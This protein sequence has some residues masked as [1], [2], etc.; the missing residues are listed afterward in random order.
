MRRWIS[1]FAPLTLLLSATIAEAGDLVVVTSTAPTFAPGKMVA[2]GAS[3]DLPKGAQ[4]TLVSESGQ[5]VTLKGPRSGPAGATATK[6]KD[7]NLVKALS[8]LVSSGGKETEAL[9]AMR[10]AGGTSGPG[11]P[12]M[13]NIGRSGK[14]CVAAGKGPELWRSDSASEVTLTLKGLKGGGKVSLPWPAG[15][16][17]LAWPSAV[18]LKDGASY[19]VRIKGSPTARRLTVHLV[20][21]TLPSDAHRAVWMAEKGCKRQAKRLLAAMK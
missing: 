9:G 3:I 19:M 1:L 4:V 20:P 15:S 13:V 12:W 10:S 5:M 8:R 11:S 21:G 14:V 2:A 7:G 16:Q 17:T 6:G 18:A